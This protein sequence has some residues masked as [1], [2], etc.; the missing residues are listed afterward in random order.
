MYAEMSLEFHSESREWVT[1]ST[2]EELQ[3]GGHRLLLRGLCCDRLR[4][5]LLGSCLGSLL[6]RGVEDLI[7]PAGWYDWGLSSRRKYVLHPPSP[8]LLSH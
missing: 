4:S 5:Y 2:E 6:A 8:A 3:G 1:D 7:I